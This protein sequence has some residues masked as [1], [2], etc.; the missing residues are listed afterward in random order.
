MAVYK[1]GKIKIN[2]RVHRDIFEYY[3]SRHMLNMS[4]CIT[5]Y[6]NKH[7]Y[8]TLHKGKYGTCIWTII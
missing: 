3:M 4:P 2:Y 1:V 5:K 8:I 6:A 7:L